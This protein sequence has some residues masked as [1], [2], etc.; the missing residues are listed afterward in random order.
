[1]RLTLFL[2]I[3]IIS[4]RSLSFHQPAPVAFRP[5]AERDLTISY[6][7]TITSK[8][9]GTGIAETYNGGIETL[10]AGAHVARMRLVSLMRIQS[11][12]IT[13]DKGLLKSVIIIK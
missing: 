1:M 8:K 11:I 5:E 3:S 7:I 4:L 2:V 12:F 9:P 6:S 13:I 10:F